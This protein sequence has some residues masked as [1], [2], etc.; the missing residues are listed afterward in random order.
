MDVNWDALDAPTLEWLHAWGKDNEIRAHGYGDMLDDYLGSIE[1][2]ETWD[3]HDMAGTP[4]SPRASALD[5]DG[6]R[7][8]TERGDGPRGHEGGGD[9]DFSSTRYDSWSKADLL[10]EADRRGVDKKG[11]KEDLV[12]RLVEDDAENLPYEHWTENELREECKERGMRA[13]G[14]KQ[15]LV[16]A[17]YKYDK[18]VEEGGDAK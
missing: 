18:K 16:N 9:G 8:T 2:G 1:R 15:D 6:R 11:T 12:A 7:Y 5:P 14:S 13:T 3:P 4:E 10:R 17:L